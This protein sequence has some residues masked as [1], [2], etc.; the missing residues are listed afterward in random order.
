MYHSQS[1]FKSHKANMSNPAQQDDKKEWEKVVNQRWINIEALQEI[2]QKT[3]EEI[4]QLAKR[5]LHQVVR[6]GMRNLIKHPKSINHKLE[7][8]KRVWYDNTYRKLPADPAQAPKPL[9]RQLAKLIR[10]NPRSPG[11]C[12]RWVD[13]SEAERER[14]A[15][16]LEN[17]NDPALLEHLRTVDDNR[18]EQ[19]QQKTRNL[20]DQEEN[21]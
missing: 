10:N 12:L 14:D 11:P 20:R 7:V 4:K 2:V 9:L 8:E 17:A 15:A 21:E 13:T 16:M 6:Q 1:Q 18:R 5:D 3:Q 19:Y